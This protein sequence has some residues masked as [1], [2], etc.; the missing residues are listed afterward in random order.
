ML[1]PV[2]SACALTFLASAASAAVL[3]FETGFSG[4]KTAITGTEFQASSGVSFSSPNGLYIVEVG[5]KT[6]GFVPFDRPNPADAFG[7]YFLTSDFGTVTA[8]TIDFAEAVLATSFDV[9]D[10]D[11]RGNNLEVFTFIARDATGNALATQTVTGQD[12]NAGNRAVTRIGFSGLGSLIS[13]IE[14]TGTTFGGTRKIGI[15]FDNFNTTVNTLQEP[16]PVPLPAGAP[17]A[18]LGLGALGLLRARRKAA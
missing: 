14:I 11:G 5:G 15:A 6:D 10:I 9:A 12:A 4:N 2:L 13:Q 8:L 1:R 3:D 17:L 7:D 18:L 16:S